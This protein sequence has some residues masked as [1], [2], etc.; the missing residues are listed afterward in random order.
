M[1]DFVYYGML[2]DIYKDLLN[3]SSKEYFSL[4]YEEN[5][6]LQ[7]I[8]DNKKVSKSYVGNIIKKTTDKLNEF[9]KTLRIFEQ[10]EKLNKLLEINNLEELKNKLKSIIDK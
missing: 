10:K 7:E 3:E 6:T 9:E 2:F 4:Y 8:A 1:T 5:L